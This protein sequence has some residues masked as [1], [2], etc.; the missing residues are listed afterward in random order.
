MLENLQLQAVGDHIIVHLAEEHNRGSASLALGPIPAARSDRLEGF[1][2][3]RRV[4]GWGRAFWPEGRAD[5]AGAPENR[6][7]RA[8]HQ[9]S[10]SVG[11]SPR[12]ARGV[13]PARSL[14]RRRAPT[15]GGGSGGGSR[16]RGTAAADVA[17]DGGQ[18]APRE[19]G[20]RGGGGGS[21]SGRRHHRSLL[22][23]PP[24][25]PGSSA[26]NSP[27]PTAGPPPPPHPQPL[28]TPERR[29]E[30]VCARERATGR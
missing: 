5:I 19:Q 6:E 11:G 30:H 29:S 2:E 27:H 8:L 25:Q 24:S 22:Q 1:A 7:V 18:V 12:L 3:R 10:R 14:R 17:V 20:S 26:Q 23:P 16:G 28:H 21:S 15:L 9:G 4:R 13:H